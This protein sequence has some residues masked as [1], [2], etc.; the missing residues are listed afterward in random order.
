MHPI[1]LRLGLSESCLQ[2]CKLVVL[3]SYQPSSCGSISKKYC[4]KILC[5]YV[6]LFLVRE[7][8]FRAARFLMLIGG[9]ESPRTYFVWTYVRAGEQL[10]Q[11]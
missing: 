5:D 10:Q 4:I 1:N 11:L 7:S 8:S 6:L 3:V 9:L 2:Y